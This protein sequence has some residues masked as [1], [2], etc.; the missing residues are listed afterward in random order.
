[1]LCPALGHPIDNPKK[2]KITDLFAW[3]I[4]CD[5]LLMVAKRRGMQAVLF[6]NHNRTYT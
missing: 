4:L 3:P 2:Y 6:R 5:T 1:L